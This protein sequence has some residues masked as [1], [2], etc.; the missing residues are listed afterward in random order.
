MKF[1]IETILDVS[2]GS[3]GLLIPVFKMD[4]SNLP[5]AQEMNDAHEIHDMQPFLDADCYPY[6]LAPRTIETDIGELGVIAFRSFDLSVFVGSISDVFS[7]RDTNQQELEEHPFLDMQLSR[8]CGVPLAVLM[9][10]WRSAGQNIFGKAL[11]DAWARSELLI[12]QKQKEIW[13]RINEQPEEQ[14]DTFIAHLNDHS[15]EFLFRWLV[16]FKNSR[17]WNKVWL[18]AFRLSPFDERMPILARD[19]LVGRLMSGEDFN[20]IRLVL[21]IF[22]EYLNDRNDEDFRDALTEY[23]FERNKEYHVFLHPATMPLLL[24]MNTN[25]EISPR[26]SLE[27][28]DYIIVRIGNDDR[29]DAAFRAAQRLRKAIVD[30]MNEQKQDLEYIKKHPTTILREFRRR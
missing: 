5:Y 29:Y 11:G 14:R 16:D 30:Y 28:I 24:I 25:F 27:F 23:V 8:L 7:F 21:F 12:H 26:N 6:Q 10:K 4:G 22:L 18:R 13:N 20:E 15:F 2:D 19:W 17:H 3:P 1:R 9:D